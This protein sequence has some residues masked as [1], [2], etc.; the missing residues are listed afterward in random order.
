MEWIVIQDALGVPPTHAQ[1]RLFASR[2]LQ[3]SGDTSEIGKNWMEGFLRRNPLVKTLRGKPLDLQRINGATTERIKG[4]F[5]LL[6]IPEIHHIKQAN[7]YNMDETGI[8]E[9]MG[10]NS[11]VLGGSEKRFTYKKDHMNRTWISI[12]ECISAIG[13]ALSLLVIFPGKSV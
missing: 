11:L 5:T 12:I 7:R 6:Q 4:F 1:V 3:A 9:A 8:M 2:I 13:K 10:S